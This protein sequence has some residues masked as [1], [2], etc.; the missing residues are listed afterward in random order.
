MEEIV[1]ILADNTESKDIAYNIYDYPW[2]QVAEKCKNNTVYDYKS[3]KRRSAPY[4]LNVPAALDIETTSVTFS[5][6]LKASYAFVYHWQTCIDDTVCFG[7]T[8]EELAQWLLD[9]IDALQLNSKTRYLPIYIHN[10]SFENQFL[11][12]LFKMIFGDTDTFYTDKHAA[13][14]IRTGKGIEFR[15]SYKLTNKSFFMWT[16]EMKCRYRKRTDVGYDYKKFRVPETLMSME[17]KSYCYCDVR[18]LCEAL[19]AELHGKINLANIPMTSTGFVRRDTLK[20]FEDYDLYSNG[21]QVDEESKTLFDFLKP[22]DPYRRK[23]GNSFR[24]DRKLVKICPKVYTL[25]KDAG[26]GGNTHANSFRTNKTIYDV[27]SFDRRSSYPAVIMQYKFPVGKFVLWNAHTESEFREF[28]AD[29]KKCTLAR[30]F[31]ENIKIKK[32]NVCPYISRSKCVSIKSKKETR[33]DNGRVYFSSGIELVVT[34]IDWQIICDT[35]DFDLVAWTDVYRCRKDYLPLPVRAVNLKYFL[36]KTKLKGVDDYLYLK[37]KNLLNAIFGMMYTDIL[38]HKHIYDFDLT[39]YQVTEPKLETAI[40]K[41]YS[42]KSQCLRYEWGIYVTAWAR[43]ELQLAINFLG[44][45]FIYA[46]TDS[47]KWQTDDPMREKEI[48]EWFDKRNS[49]IEELSEKM[50]SYVDYNGKRYHLGVWEC[51]HE[52]SNCNKAYKKFKTFGAKKY[53]YETY[54]PEII[55]DD[56]GNVIEERFFHITVAGLAK[57]KGAKYIGSIDNF[58]LNLE[59]P[60]GDSGRTVSVWKDEPLHYININGNKILAGSS[61][62][63][64]DTTYTFDLAADY[65]MLLRNGQFMLS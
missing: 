53:A 47:V 6:N 50:L 23:K 16:K 60:E 39:D 57:E 7:R 15:C 58:Q 59:I 29:E 22:T 9:M 24:K 30:V 1:N 51:E 32:G 17:E 62:A 45:D 10:L 64:A 28:M 42:S 63:M 4:C 49:E 65:R 31:L 19:K 20:L 25:C 35:Y 37:S 13:L 41:F 54:L 2:T 44:G 12:E 18:G 8:L 48:L 33:C 46:D 27:Y 40:N 14:Q 56:D 21:G 36:G 11:R 61:V 34:E 3:E 38:H 52:F 55:K 43:W 26:R 5:D